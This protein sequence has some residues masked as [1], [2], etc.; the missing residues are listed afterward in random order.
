MN[1]YLKIVL[2]T[3]LFAVFIVIRAFSTKLFYDP[4][5]YYFL[6]DYLYT[7]V[8]DID[9]TR[10][11]TSMFFRYTLNTIVSLCIVWLL[12]NRRDYVRF[13]IYFYTVAFLIL[14]LIFMYLLKDKFQSGY[15]LPFYV[16]RFIIQPLFILILLP[17]FYYQKLSKR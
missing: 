13:S 11:A 10:L 12:F 9:I 14:M 3:S 16:R 1:K 15:L 4:L 17:A 5:V 2:I 7:A 8:P 6:N